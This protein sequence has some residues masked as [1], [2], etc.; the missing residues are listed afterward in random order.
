M[1]KI[2]TFILFAY[3]FSLNAEYIVYKKNEVPDPIIDQQEYAKIYAVLMNYQWPMV[4]G[5]AYK[6]PKAELQEI[7]AS[8]VKAEEDF[9]RKKLQ[10]LSPEY[11]IAFIPTILYELFSIYAIKFDHKA[12]PSFALLHSW[13]PAVSAD[14]H[15]K[16]QG[17]LRNFSASE[18]D[19]YNLYKD[20]NN[21]EFVSSKL[22]E[23]LSV[24]QAHKDL[25]T[26]LIHFINGIAPGKDL[27]K[28]MIAH[29]KAIAQKI[30][31]AL[32]P[33]LDIDLQYFSKIDILEKFMNFER[34]AHGNNRGLLYRGGQPHYGIYIVGARELKTPLEAAFFM[35]GEQPALAELKKG[36]TFKLFPWEFSKAIEKFIDSSMLTAT[37][38]ISYG[39]SLLAGYWDERGKGGACAAQYFVEGRLG[40]ALLINK[41]EFLLGD[42][43]SLFKYS[44]FNTIMGLLSTG[45]FFHTRTISYATDSLR[46]YWEKNTNKEIYFPGIA[47][48]L[49]FNKNGIIVRFG[50]QMQKV[51]ELSKYITQY[52]RILKLPATFFPSIEKTKPYYVAQQEVTAMVKAMLVVRKKIKEKRQKTPIKLIVAS[53]GGKTR[54]VIR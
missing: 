11:D 51:Y 53:R 43:S 52:A 32:G 6:M 34:E 24:P 42:L 29:Q 46:E 18:Q 8:K 19:W 21:Y 9:I 13:R 23:K 35:T 36:K 4:I 31:A 10:E 27:N 38:S 25:N 7:T 50:D 48:R 26:A 44:L 14:Y 41:H 16:E 54:K 2:L 5:S 15:T 1:K 20:M 17:L 45:E 28:T 30:M 3:A 33:T 40:Y 22:K 37:V 49:P 39:N 12:I 47:E